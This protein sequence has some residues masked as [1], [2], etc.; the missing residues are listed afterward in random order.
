MRYLAGIIGSAF[1]VATII[2]SPSVHAENLLPNIVQKGTATFYSVESNG[3]KR[4]DGGVFDNADLIIGHKTLPI[5]TRVR[6]TNLDN[7]KTMVVTI[8]DNSE[9]GKTNAD[10]V[11]SKTLFV[12]YYLDDWDALEG[13]TMPIEYTILS[14]IPD[15]DTPA[16][17]TNSAEQPETEEQSAVNQKSKYTQEMEQ[18]KLYRKEI[19]FLQ[20]NYQENPSEELMEDIEILS[21]RIKRLVRIRKERITAEKSLYL[22]FQEGIA[23]FYSGRFNGRRTSTG[24][25][26]SN[27]KLTAAHRTLPFG[28]KVRV[29]SKV[30]GS[31]VVVIINDRGPYIDGRVIDLSKEAF[32]QLF[33][34]D[35]AS[36]S[37]GITNVELYIVEE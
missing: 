10:F 28:T 7:G 22:P 29:K 20:K 34:G 36:L 9:P 16:I 32:A 31:E 37:R 19:Q 11:F 18:I 30:N 35:W 6:I 1:A 26:F 2:M 25:R 3:K 5:D 21:D 4:D 14:G 17:Q 33:G 8:D 23:S 15:I 13:K 24:E 12:K 27:Q